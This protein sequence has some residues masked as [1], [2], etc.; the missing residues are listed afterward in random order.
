VN[1]G[2]LGGFIKPDRF[3]WVLLWFYGDRGLFG[4]ILALMLRFGW[5]WWSMVVDGHVLGLIGGISG[6]DLT[7]FEEWGGGLPYFRKNLRNLRKK[8]KKDL[9][10]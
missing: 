9:V 8:M 10:A 3:R 7:L 4:L 5:I 6:L 1:L 2:V